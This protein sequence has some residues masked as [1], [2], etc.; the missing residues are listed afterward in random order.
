MFPYI[1]AGALGFAVAKLFEEDEAPKFNDGGSVL[2]AP[3]GNPSN[4]TPEQYK[5]VRTPEFKSWFGDWE[6][7]PET[8]SKVVDSNGEPLIVYHGTNNDFNTFEK[9]K[10]GLN[11]WQSKSDLYGGGFFFTDKKNK[12]FRGKIKEVFLKIEKPLLNVIEDK[13]GYEV[14][15]YHATDN[16]DLNSTSYFQKAKENRN[17]GIITKTPRGSLYVVFEPNQIKLADGSNTTFDGS[18]PDIRYAGGGKVKKVKFQ[19]GR[20]HV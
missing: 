6:N 12:A 19:I 20:A 8:A 10:I 11:H 18:N 5:L 16:F 17:N 1:I 4:L 13:Y 2:L 7:S 9:S 14:D 3:N 15:Y